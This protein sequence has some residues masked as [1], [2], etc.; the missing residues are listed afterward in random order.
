MPRR[1]ADR[2]LFRSQSLS[3]FDVVPPSA[4]IV[5][6]GHRGRR[7]APSLS[8]GDTSKRERSLDA[9]YQS[10]ALTLN[11]GAEL[12]GGKP[13]L[14]QRLACEWPCVNRDGGNIV[15]VVKKQ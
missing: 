15:R 1:A 5:A 8:P 7:R 11:Y 2:R 14:A 12:R 9:Q 4:G 3:A 6:A 13:S 10:A